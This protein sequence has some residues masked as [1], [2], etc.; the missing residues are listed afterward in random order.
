MIQHFLWDEPGTWKTW[1]WL[2]YST[3]RNPADK[4]C[5][6]VTD[7]EKELSKMRVY[8]PEFRTFSSPWIVSLCALQR[9]S[10]IKTCKE[11][12]GDTLFNH[13][14]DAVFIHL[15][16]QEQWQQV[17]LD[18]CQYWILTV[19]RL[20]YYSVSPKLKKLSV[21][22]NFFDHWSAQVSH[23][24]LLQW[25]VRALPV[26]HAEGDTLG[27]RCKCPG[28]GGTRRLHGDGNGAV[29]ARFNEK[30]PAAVLKAW[31]VVNCEVDVQPAAEWIKDMTNEAE[32]WS[33]LCHTV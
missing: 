12:N 2:L 8:S 7:L 27:L 31:D 20:L 9:V 15:V 10:G 16:W 11:K 22:D 30:V 3:I 21:L 26:D 4:T 5:K 19:V 13:P 18:P 1:W 14:L 28:D 33:G 25:S 23:F 6:L 17:I 32:S 29:A 24:G